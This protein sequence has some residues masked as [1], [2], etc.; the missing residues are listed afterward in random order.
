MVG[1]DA[2][3]A[4]IQAILGDVQPDIQGDE[5]DTQVD[6]KEEVPTNGSATLENAV[7]DLSSPA[8]PAPVYETPTTEKPTAKAAST[9]GRTVPRDK[10]GGPAPSDRRH[11]AATHVQRRPAAAPAAA[12]STAEDTQPT[13]TLKQ[14][15]TR[16]DL[17]RAEALIDAMR[18]V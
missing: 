8:C 15:S 4:R 14:S 3:N 10:D 12:P 7:S 1:S 13:S 2:D 17:A 16:Q 9:N 11:A 18:C 5:H 6:F